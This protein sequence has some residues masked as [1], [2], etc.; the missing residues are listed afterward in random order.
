MLVSVKGLIPTAEHTDAYLLFVPLW[1]FG[2]SEL[3]HG[4]LPLWNPHIYC[5]TPCHSSFQTAFLYPPN[6]LFLIAPLA[7]GICLSVVLHVFLLGFFMA[8]WA[9]N[10]GLHP[11]ACLLAG[12]M[13]TLGGTHFLFVYS[14]GLVLLCVTAWVPLVFLSIDKVFEKRS[15]GWCMVG[16]FATSMQILGGLPQV[17]FYTAFAAAL[18]SGIRLIRATERAKTISLLLMFALL[19]PLLTA[20]QLWPGL[21][22]ARDSVRS[23]IGSYEFATGFSF[24]PENLLTLLAPGFFGDTTSGTYTACWGRWYFW[25]TSLFIGITGFVLAVYGAIFGDRRV[26]RY[27]TLMVVLLMLVAFGRYTPVFRVLYQVILPLRGFRGPTKMAFQASMFV[28]MLSAVGLDV[29]LRQPR[30][31]VGLAGATLGAALAVAVFGVAIQVSGG[32][33]SPDSAW[34]WF[35]DTVRVEGEAMRLDMTPEIVRATGRQA[36]GSLYLAS[37]TGIA[38]A[39]CLFGVQWRP[40]MAYALAA[41]GALELLVFAH[42]HR[43]TS[44]VASNR[45]SQLEAFYASRPGDYRVLQ[46]DYANHAMIARTYNLW[47]YDPLLARRYA[48]FIAFTQGQDPGTV[49]GTLDIRKLDPLF[50]MLR[51]RFALLEGGERPGTC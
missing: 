37:V 40:R 18:Y 24:P 11:V 15:V 50:G 38:L 6:W 48:E 4:N 3:A 43:A 2:F 8:L 9:R 12:L 13:A 39:A 44:D 32:S 41:L 33:G 30:R 23:G 17:L 20:A 49:T 25:E 10:R 16:V 51:C 22:C 27:S 36:A 45:I 29:L 31:V 1:D 26:K 42:A 46:S 28:S 47:G 5:G 21:E 7:K 35:M 34:A 19:P 14:G